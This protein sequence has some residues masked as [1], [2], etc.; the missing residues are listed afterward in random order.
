ML[1]VC[2]VGD[3]GALCFLV[4]GD[5]RQQGVLTGILSEGLTHQNHEVVE[6]I[7]DYGLF[8]RGLAVEREGLFEEE[9]FA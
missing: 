9:E 1:I 2:V 7:E 4:E 6:A 8:S 5:V 3:L